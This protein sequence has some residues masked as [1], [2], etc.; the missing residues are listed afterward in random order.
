MCDE[1]EYE[2]E[3]VRE[4]GGVS[5]RF[6]DT[7]YSDIDEFFAKAVIDGERIPILY[8]WMYDFKVV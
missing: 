4:E 2:V 5:I 8:D 1:E 7:W 6:G 3:S